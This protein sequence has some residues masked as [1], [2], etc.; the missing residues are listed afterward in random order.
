MTCTDASNAPAND[1]QLMKNL[2]K[3]EELIK[4]NPA[5]Y[6]EIFLQLASLARKKLENHLGY[7]SERLVP[8]SLFSDNV[9]LAVKRKLRAAMLKNKS[10]GGNEPQKMPL[11]KN[12]SNIHLYDL[13]GKDSWKM[14]SLLGIDSEFLNIAVN[15][16]TETS[17]YLKGK[18]ILSN[19]PVVNDA[20]ERALGLA[21]EKTLIQ[22][23]NKIHN[24]KHFIKL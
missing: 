4:A 19:L 23:Q 9:P 12:F 20:A 3:S 13:V 1:L 15:K 2:L 11:S 21:T 22:P 5:L 6:P 24:V 8:F 7:L 17:S 14:F 18:E 10:D 16:W